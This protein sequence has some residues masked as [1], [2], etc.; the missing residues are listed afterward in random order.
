[1]RVRNIAKFS[2]IAVWAVV[3]ILAGSVLTSFHQAFALPSKSISSLATSRH[4]WRAL[5]VLAADCGCSRKVSEY[6]AARVV[7]KNVSEEVII[8]GASDPF[9]NRDAL[10]A[11]GLGVKS[12]RA[13]DLAPFGLKGVPLL[14]FISPAGGIAYM[15]GY[16]MGGYK[17]ALIRSQLLA[18]ARVSPLPVFGCAVS[19]ELSRE[20]D[21]LSWKS[22]EKSRQ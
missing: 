2:F 10:L 1:M 20:I 13:V 7:P 22:M 9:G 19:R 5:H 15:G 16:G 11:R 6:L 18:G 12:V 4:G 17:D 14:I 3:S 8:I 21:P